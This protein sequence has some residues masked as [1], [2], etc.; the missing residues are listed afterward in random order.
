MKKK[1]KKTKAK[2]MHNYYDKS[3]RHFVNALKNA[4]ESFKIEVSNYTLNVVLEDGTKYK[5]IKEAKHQN[6]FI[7]MKK[8]EKDVNFAV[9]ELGFSDHLKDESIK[10]KFYSSC[11]QIAPFSSKKIFNIDLNS[12][13]PNALFQLGLLSQ[14]TMDY[15]MTINKIDR[16]AAV[17]CLA[18]NKNIY[19]Y[20]F[21]ELQEVDNEKSEFVN[22]WRLMVN[23]VD[24][25]LQDLVAIDPDN[26]VFYWVDGIFFK[27]KPDFKTLEQMDYLIKECGFAYK[28]ENIRNFEL[29]RVSDKIIVNFDK[30]SRKIEQC[31]TDPHFV[32]L[33]NYM[34]KYLM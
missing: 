2:K 14:E 18:K 29:R 24:S 31:F 30:G 3:A 10:P 8:V 33:R 26:F 9:N 32:G 16:L 22:I 15:L 11:Y 23:L 25:L 12:A 6:F 17:G 1:T 7:A 13:Y 5:F 21:G 4:K 27:E 19:T 20:Q 34:T 28:N